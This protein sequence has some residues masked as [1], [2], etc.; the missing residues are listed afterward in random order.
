M[1]GVDRV[2]QVDPP[3]RHVL[4]GER[5]I[6]VQVL[7]IARHRRVRLPDLAAGAEDEARAHVREDVAF[8]AA[9]SAARGQLTEEMA[10]PVPGAAANLQHGA[11]GAKVRNRSGAYPP[12]HVLRWV[13]VGRPNPETAALGI[14]AAQ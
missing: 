13:G 9:E 6:D 5:A 2:D 14:T 4:S 8:D 12:V 1:R 7:P 10:D 11:A 3:R